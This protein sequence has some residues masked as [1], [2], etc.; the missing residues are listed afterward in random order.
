MQHLDLNLLV[1]LDALLAEASVTRAGARLGLTTSATSHALA[2]L[3]DVLGD[4]L[5]VRAGRAMALTPRGLALRDRVRA[6]LGQA[7][8][9]FAADGPF[10]AQALDRTFRIRAT[11]HAITLLG[12]MLDARMPPGV[13][14]E[15]LPNTPRDAEALRDGTIDL[16]IGIYDELPADMRVQRLFDDRFVCV[17]RANHPTIGDRLRL[18]H[19]LAARHVLVSPRG[20]PGGAIDRVLARRGESRRVA[21]VVPH[22]LAALVLVSRTSYVVTISERLA[23]Q[24]AGSLRLRIVPCPVPVEPY[25][26]SQIWHPRVDAE[27]AHRWLRH[28][29]VDA[30]RRL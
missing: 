6:A 16:A 9:V 15:F 19:Y 7:T 25:T 3:R 28:Q 26:L 30:A 24:L 23:S 17:V 13:T 12:A 27:R 2:R 22:F 10:D 5:L 4:P 18:D 29:I 1:P 20:R 11:D 8:A 14:L 21:R